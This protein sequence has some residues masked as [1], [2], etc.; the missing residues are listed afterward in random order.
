MSA[1]RHTA[2]R[3]AGRR[4]RRG[5]LVLAVG[6]LVLL[7][8]AFIAWAV[9]YAQGPVSTVT[10]GSQPSGFDWSGV[11]AALIGAVPGTITAV[12]GLIMVMRS[13]TELAAPAPPQSQPQAPPPPN[14][15]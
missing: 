14:K 8:G 6:G 3:A 5:F 9:V 12:T 15:P 2:E 10:P 7:I 11:I 13:R 1:I 4:R